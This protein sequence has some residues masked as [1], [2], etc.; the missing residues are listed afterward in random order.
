MSRRSAAR[1][2]VRRTSEP[3]S[4]QSGRTRSK[5]RA[6]QRR[7]GS[8]EHRK[9]LPRGFLDRLPRC[10][11]GDA[12]MAPVMTDTRWWDT[13][14]RLPRIQGETIGSVSTLMGERQ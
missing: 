9:S 2:S 1:I 4:N 7:A 14:S 10:V 3:I 6:F 5:G 12:P 11:P 13:P 8:V